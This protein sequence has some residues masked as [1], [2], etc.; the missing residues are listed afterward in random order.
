MINETNGI[1]IKSDDE[2]ALLDSMQ[3]LYSFNSNIDRENISAEAISKYNYETVG[4]EIC[5]VY[6]KIL[7]AN[8]KRS[9]GTP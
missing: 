3:K 8:T 2:N 1:L 9:S 4:K 7:K 5:E 6:E